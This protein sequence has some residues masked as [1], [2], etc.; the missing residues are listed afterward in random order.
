MQYFQPLPCGI[1]PTNV[2]PQLSNATSVVPRDRRMHH[3]ASSVHMSKSLKLLLCI[4]ADRHGT[5]TCF[6]SLMAQE[7]SATT[8]EVCGLLEYVRFLLINT[9]ICFY[10]STA[11]G[12]SPMVISSPLMH[13]C[14]S[15]CWVSVEA[16]WCVSHAFQKG[17][18]GCSSCLHGLCI[19]TEAAYSLKL[20]N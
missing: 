5:L 16:C 14:K 1:K 7:C 9:H 2:R 4:A 3:D 11:R 18:T 6:F 12:L 13:K 8:Q 17:D 20:F 19:H 15:C 10:R